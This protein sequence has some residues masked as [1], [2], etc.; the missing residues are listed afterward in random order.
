MLPV[1]GKASKIDNPLNLLPGKYLQGHQKAS[2]TIR[3]PLSFIHQH[4][5]D[6]EV[7]K[8]HCTILY[9]KQALYKNTNGK[10]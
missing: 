1:K 10:T 2:H 7:N 4:Y 6:T 9:K 5:F 8:K 3:F